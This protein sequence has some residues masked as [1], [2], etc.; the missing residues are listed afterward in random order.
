VT[1]MA[2][3]A[4]RDSSEPNKPRVLLVDDTLDQLD[5]YAMVLEPHCDVLKASRGE[6]AYATATSELPDVIV[7]DLLLPDVDGFEVCRRLQSNR[8]T[9]AIPIIFLTG[10]DYSMF[11]AMAS[12]ECANVFA[13]LKKPATGDQLLAS[14]RAAVNATRRS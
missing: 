14:I 7:L 2:A 6:T 5:L 13:I 11:K 10:D 9:A 3:S 4:S 1:S 12:A 8:H